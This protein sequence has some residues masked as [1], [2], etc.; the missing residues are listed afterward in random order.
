MPDRFCYALLGK[1]A[2]VKAKI[3]YRQT[4]RALTRMARANMPSEQHKRQLREIEAEQRR[5]NML[6]V[7]VDSF[8]KQFQRSPEVSGNR[9]LDN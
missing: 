4:L 8:A 9:K 7:A 5:H 6:K 3:H 2:P 1:A